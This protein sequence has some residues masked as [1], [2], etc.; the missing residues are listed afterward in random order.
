MQRFKSPGSA[1]KFLTAHAAGLP[2]IDVGQGGGAIEQ[3]FAKF[4]TLLREVG[5]RTYEAISDAS[6]E[7]LAQYQPAEYAAYLRNA[8]YADHPKTG[9]SSQRDGRGDDRRAAERLLPFD[10]Y[11]PEI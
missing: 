5:A 4:K 8:G 2:E 11:T 7:I 10:I 1:Q 6:A 3:V 9:R